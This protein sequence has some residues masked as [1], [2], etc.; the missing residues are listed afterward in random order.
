MVMNEM[1]ISLPFATITDYLIVIGTIFIFQAAS[2]ARYVDRHIGLA[3]VQD[4]A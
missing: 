2:I 3:V 1:R 4:Q